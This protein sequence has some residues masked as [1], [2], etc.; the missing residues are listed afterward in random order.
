MIIGR[1][2]GARR[3][4]CIVSGGRV[5]NVGPAGAVPLSVSHKHCKIT[6]AGSNISIENLNELN[7]TYVDGNQIFSKGITSASRVQLGK[8]KYTVSLQQILQLACGVLSGPKPEAP[9][10]SLAPMEAVWKEYE[11]RM[12]EIQN[13]AAKAANKQRLQGILSMSAALVGCIE[14]L[15]PARFVIIF[16]AL[17]VGVY[18]FIKGNRGAIV[19]RQLHDLN[20]EFATKYKC[21][22]PK[23]GRPFGA[24][25]YYTLKFNRQ[26]FSC[27]CRYT[28]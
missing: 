18:F 23:C 6:V 9:T 25:P 13:S 7:V 19:Q 15:G 8:D 14:S 10:F 1:E 24:I 3:L 22:N 26:C 20:E 4:H 2:E 5:F 27:G 11:R 12:M 28:H 17:L 21:P 16:A